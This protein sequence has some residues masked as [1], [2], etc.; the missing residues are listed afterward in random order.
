VP[1]PAATVAF[2]VVPEPLGDPSA[3]L[4]E[5]ADGWFVIPRL[6]FVTVQVT[7]LLVTDL[8]FASVTVQ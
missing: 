4:P 6:V 7:V 1:P 8:L 3:P 5:I 2:E